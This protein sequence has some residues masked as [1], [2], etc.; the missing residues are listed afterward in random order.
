MQKY[1]TN[2]LTHVYY[3]E[4]S[5]YCFPKMSLDDLKKSKREQIIHVPQL[6]MRV[7]AA[8]PF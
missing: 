3:I 4:A 8:K 2:T 6:Q 7:G 1:S 5:L